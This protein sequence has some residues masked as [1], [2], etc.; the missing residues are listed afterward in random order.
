LYDCQHFLSRKASEEEAWTMKSGTLAKPAALRIARFM[1]GLAIGLTNTLPGVLAS[2]Q[3][4]PW[5]APAFTA[6]PSAMVSFAKHLNAEQYASVTVFL[7]ENH[8]SIDSADRRKDVT[9]RIYRVET[10]GAVQD[11]SSIS[12]QWSPWRQKRPVIRARVVSPDGT[13]HTLDPKVLSEAPAHDQRPD[14]YEDDRVYSGPL[15]AVAA[16]SIVEL[17]I[18][19][20]DTAPEFDGGRLQRFYFGAPVPVQRTVLVLEAPKSTPLRYVTHLL[21]DM[22]VS[23][24]ESGNSV[25]VTFEQGPM[26]AIEKEDPFTPGD[27]ITWPSV[28]FS[29]GTSW[30]SVASTYEREIE[31]AIKPQDVSK[32]MQG[33][34]GLTGQ[35][36]I[37]HLVNN[38]HRNVRYTGLE[39][40]ASSL[41]PHPA[42][43]TVARGYG[44]CKDEA[45]VLIS[46]LRA[47][48]I[49][50][51]LALLATRERDDVS[52]ELA[53]IGTFD[54]AIVYVPGDPGTWID[55]TAEFSQPGVLPWGA[56]GR[57]ALIIAPTTET[58]VRT[59]TARSSDNL[60]AEKREFYLAEYG[61]ARIVETSQPKGSAESY[62][63]GNFG[64]PES[65]DVNEELDKYVKS[66]YLAESLTQF[67][68]TPGND[69][70]RPFEMSLKVASGK[71]GYSSLEDAVVAIPFSSIIDRYP[72]FV[73]SG[74]D[75]EN[76]NGA[77]KPVRK[78]D[79]EIP[80]FITEWQYKIIPPPGF[81]APA[82]PQDREIHLGPAVLTQKYHVEGDGSASVVFRFDSV[83]ARYSLAELKAL[84]QALNSTNTEAIVIRFPQTGAAQLAAGNV[85]EALASYQALIKQ[86]PAESIHHLQL[87]SALLTAGFGDQARAEAN[88]AVALDATSATAYAVLGWVLQHDAIGRRFGKGFDLQG[89]IAA[90]RKSVQLDPKQWTTHADLAVLL[91][92]DADGE[93]YS[94][95]AAL[96]EAVAEYR[97]LKQLDKGNGATYD[98]NL[99]YALFYAKQWKEVSEVYAG[100]ASTPVR[101][102]I[103]IA[104]IAARDGSE[105][106]LAESARLGSSES[107]RSNVLVEAANLLLRLRMYPRVLELLTAAAS[108][109]Q[110]SAQVRT[111]IQVLSAVRPYEQV[112][113]PEND[114]RRVVQQMFV[115]TWS[116]HSK[117]DD[118]LSLVEVDAGDRKDEVKASVRQARLER[119]S[120]GKEGVPGD[121]GV[122]IVVSNLKLTSDGTDSSGYRIRVFGMSDKPQAAL[123]ARRPAGYRIV[124]F[125]GDVRMV[126]PEVLRRLDAN[127][128]KGAKQWLD[129]AREE[130]VLQGGDDPLA[131]PVFP[132][133]WTRGD[134]PNP[135]KMRL[136]A[137][138]LILN[139]AAI[140]E[141]IGDL[142][143][144]RAKA[145]E[146]DQTKLDL[147][148]ASA[149]WK[150]KNWALLRE[151]AGRLL[152][153]YPN[154]DTAFSYMT[155]ACF[156]EQDWT[157]WEKT[158]AARQARLPDDLIAVRSAASLADASGDFVKARSILRGLIDSG[159]AELGDV[160]NYSWF[161]LFTS[162]VSDD[163]VSVLEHSIAARATNAGFA[164]PA[165]PGLPLRSS[166][167]RQRSKR[168][169]AESH[170]L[171][172]IRRTNQRDLV[173]VC[174]HR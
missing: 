167:E 87:A 12:A 166:R 129:W 9:H 155:V 44:D 85:R 149:S 131:G 115:W 57:L 41:I 59:P 74:D 121:V 40:G 25:I 7:E 117:P 144:A 168:A 135:D 94:P 14:I 133:F 103:A 114:P 120:F 164:S 33:S 150:L 79:A 162:K 80:P 154:S 73:Y 116:P 138:A 83:K 22:K 93:R 97:A 65:R 51:N 84:S 92:H 96:N 147:A 6:E 18:V 8:Y 34:A 21:P 30:K 78:Q 112:L 5:D 171:S 55:A 11:W 63:R 19:S 27:V 142:K 130:Q 106:A 109:Q 160:N 137:V 159:R 50:A 66:V 156:G 47:A 70:E 58:L 45:I 36:L 158:V 136:A 132:R 20:E 29:T 54:H 119:S 141:H 100:L 39:F 90:Y 35:A 163:D 145:S 82:M 24:V 128:L 140:Q 17:E 146:A 28:E 95:R 174:Q 13:A 43:E 81:G 98:D 172:R 76:G 4:A 23:K 91:E 143:A 77:N 111:R 108:S 89:A 99:L 139:S 48:G 157:V 173:R 15:P 165:D 124:A 126:G 69:L 151:S 56:Q 26:P 49:P 71:R 46:V 113:A 169:L 42:G 37:L 75:S 86:H 107:A 88:K 61:P 161:A 68:H 170:G 53:G 52:P 2:A 64:G 102:S 153:A 123:V 32:L 105:G 62:Y 125:G 31:S 118:I 10:Q 3:T 60:L 127:D 104:A 38:L 110:D 152:A 1:A 148:L 122:D 67:E 134:E 16:G 72:Q 101:Q